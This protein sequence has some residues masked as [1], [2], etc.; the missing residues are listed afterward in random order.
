[1]ESIEIIYRWS[2]NSGNVEVS[3][4][5]NHENYFEVTINSDSTS[6]KVSL[7]YLSKN[8]LIEISEMLIYISGLK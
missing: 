2:G 6:E 3:T 1:M 4:L 7:D 5:P 8:D